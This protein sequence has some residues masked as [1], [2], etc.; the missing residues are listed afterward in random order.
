VL[1]NK[2]KEDLQWQGKFRIIGLE[3]LWVYK[4]QIL[5]SA[6]CYGSWY[7]LVVMEMAVEEKVLTNGGKLR[8]F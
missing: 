3:K 7:L 5:F 8:M 1:P 2:R 4:T 6:E